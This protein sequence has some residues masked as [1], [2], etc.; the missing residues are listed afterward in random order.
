ML[1]RLETVPVRPNRDDFMLE[2]RHLDIGTTQ[3]MMCNC[4]VGAG[5]AQVVWLARGVRLGPNAGCITSF[6][7]S[8]AA[9]TPQACSLLLP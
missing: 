8:S 3:S 1:Y 5:R 6:A 2:K 9:A 4:G 7:Q